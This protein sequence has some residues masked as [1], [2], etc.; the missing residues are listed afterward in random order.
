MI[1]RLL[2]PLVFSLDPE[3]AHRLAMTVAKLLDGAARSGL[4]APKPDPILRQDLWGLH[5][6]NPIG[7]AGGFDKSAHAPHAWGA[8]GF[9]FA[10][11]GTI[12]AEAQPG[13]PTPR[14]FRL[15]AD[16]ALINRLGFNNDGA[17]A[18]AAHLAHGWRQPA[19]PLGINV[20]KS[21][22]TPL[23]RANEDY[24]RSLRA[25][26]RFA[27]YVAINVSSPN[28]PGLRDLQAEDQLA[29]L[30][31]DLAAANRELARTHG[32]PEK[33][34]LVK[35]SPDLGDDGVAAVVK[36][37]LAGGAAGLIATNTTLSRE[38]LRTPIEESGGLSGRP[39]R[40]RST[41][42]VR[43]LYQ[44]AGAKL[45]IIAVGGIFDAGDAYEKL[46]AGASLVQLYT[47]LIYEG[48]FLV[49]RIARDLARRLRS[50]AVP[51]ISAI[52]R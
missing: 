3:R 52:R 27:D 19:I 9:G 24:V 36:I 51:H 7:L 39:L 42:V 25:L 26:F 33:P 34:L 17:E 20:G 15:A 1:Y 10:E 31:A 18:V 35:I 29:R 12:T 45:P 23:E 37:A 49:R 13:N 6:V 48:P 40:A 4:G 21:R 30:L 50:E 43:L 22:V 11:L 8:L 14:I 2:R 38:G 32:A 44:A 46:R 5:F 41:H 47:G 28:T 16:E